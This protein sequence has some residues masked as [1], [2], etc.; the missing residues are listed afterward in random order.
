M[1]AARGGHVPA[2]N[3]LL[4]LTLRVATGDAV[5]RVVEDS[6][7]HLLQGRLNGGDL[8]DDIYAVSVS[9]EPARRAGFQE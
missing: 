8:R 9:E 3:E 7:R 4:R 6:E 5:A 2:Q 1:I